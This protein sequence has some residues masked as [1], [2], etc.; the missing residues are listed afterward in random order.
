MGGTLQYERS[1]G[2]TRFVMSVPLSS[3]HA[4]RQSVMITAG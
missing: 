4:K 1:L 3:E 2:L